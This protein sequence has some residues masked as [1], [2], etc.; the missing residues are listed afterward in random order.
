L[1]DNAHA[2]G[3]DTAARMSAAVYAFYFIVSFVLG[4]MPSVMPL[5]ALNYAVLV[6]PVAAILCAAAGVIVSVRRLRRGDEGPV[7]VL[8]LTGAAAFAATFAMHVIYSYQRHLTYGWMMDAYPRYYLPL[9]ALIPLGGLS[10][11]C[12]IDNPRARAWL[13]GFLIAGP[14]VFRLL[15]APLG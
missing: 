13:G 12:A 4:W 11:L 9:A 1:K 2:V 7:D 3:W 15:G 8:L 14:I 5:N 10:L 6:I